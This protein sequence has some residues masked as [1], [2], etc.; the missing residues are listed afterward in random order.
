MTPFLRTVARETSG[1]AA[2]VFGTQ[3][4]SFRLVHFARTG[5]LARMV[6]L[7]CMPGSARD[8]RLPIDGGS[9]VWD[10]RNGEAN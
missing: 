2:A 5:A 6:R 9:S 7:L 4:P 3:R 1:T 10:A 8:S